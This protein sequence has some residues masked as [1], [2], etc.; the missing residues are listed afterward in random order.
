MKHLL[1]AAV[2]LACVAALMA[3]SAQPS[4]RQ[5]E[6]RELNQDRR[7]LNRDH[8]E[9][10]Q[11]RRDLRYDRARADSWQGRTEWRDFHGVRPGMWFAPGY[12]YRPV[13]H[14]GWPRRPMCRSATAGA[15]CRTS[16]TTACVRRPPATAGSTP[17]ATS[18]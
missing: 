15:R 8:R 16:A 14:F 18:S 7:D 6:R 4:D 9:I 17:T 12:G 10:N 11:D 2:A 5:D 1:Y 13:S 3:A